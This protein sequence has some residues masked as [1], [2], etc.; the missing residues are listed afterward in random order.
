MGMAWL[1]RFVALMTMFTVLLLAPPLPALAATGNSVYVKG[2]E[3]TS[4]ETYVFHAN[5]SNNLTKTDTTNRLLTADTFI[6]AYQQGTSTTVFSFDDD[7]NLWANSNDLAQYEFEVTAVQ[8]DMDEGNQGY[9]IRMTGQNVDGAQYLAATQTIIETVYQRPADAYYLTGGKPTEF[10]GVVYP[11]LPFVYLSNS[12]CTW[13]WDDVEGEFYTRFTSDI[14]NSGTPTPGCLEDGTPWGTYYS[15]DGNDGNKYL[16]GWIGYLS[17]IDY[18]DPE[19]AGYLNLYADAY[20][21]TNGSDTKV[22]LVGV[23][24]PNGINRLVRNS[25]AEV[26]RNPLFVFNRIWSIDGV[27]AGCA[28]LSVPAPPYNIWRLW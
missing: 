21:N 16:I 18:D 28:S 11:T 27:T 6:P 17:Y 20:E 12:P 22:S 13:H 7:G 26:L 19:Y 2:G 23:N 10:D 3:P 14:E 5:I 4:G 1:K 25:L 8:G 9:H 24:A 15:Y